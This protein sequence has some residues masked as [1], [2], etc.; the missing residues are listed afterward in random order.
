[1]LHSEIRMAPEKVCII[2]GARAILHNIAILLKEPMED[3]EVEDE[4]NVN[5]A[6][7]GPDQGRSVRNHICRTYFS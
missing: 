6:Y 1:M 7:D 4:M 5:D 2:I 3:G